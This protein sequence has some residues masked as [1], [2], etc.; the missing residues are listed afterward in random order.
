MSISNTTF[1]PY[2]NPAT[3]LAS[4]ACRLITMKQNK[5]LID[6]V[7]KAFHD[8]P[9]D[10]PY[11]QLLEAALKFWS[12]NIKK[13]KLILKDI[14]KNE[15]IEEIFKANAEYFLFNTNLYSISFKKNREL[16]LEERLKSIISRSEKFKDEE[17]SATHYATSAKLGLAKAFFDGGTSGISINRIRSF[18]LCLEVISASTNPEELFEAKRIISWVYYGGAEDLEDENSAIRTDWEKAFLLFEELRF[19]PYISPSEKAKMEIAMAWIHY[20]RI[21]NIPFERQ[22]AFTIFEKHNTVASA[23]GKACIYLQGAADISID[24][25]K[26]WDL[27]Q[28]IILQGNSPYEM[29]IYKIE[30][31]RLAYRYNLPKL[32]GLVSINLPKYLYNLTV[33]P[34]VFPMD[35]PEALRAEGWIYYYGTKVIKIDH[36]KALH[37]F[38]QLY[39]HPDVLPQYKVE[40]RFGM[41]RIYQKDQNNP[42]SLEYAANLY[43]ENLK[44]K[45]ASEIDLAYSYFQL[46]NLEVGKNPI[47]AILLYYKCFC[48][49]SKL[50]IPN[51]MH[52]SQQGIKYCLYFCNISE[53]ASIRHKGAFYEEIIFHRD[54]CLQSLADTGEMRL[55]SKLTLK[56]FLKILENTDDTDWPDLKNEVHEAIHNFGNSLIL[57]NLFDEE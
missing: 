45:S 14:I 43:R 23:L 3:D 21:D 51:L 57:S 33:D 8:L 10:T 37:N 22:R 9:Y 52:N 17:S 11:A 2:S 42:F 39:N 55:E 46:G 29:L 27:L 31:M 41:A 24:R 19:S 53:H 15:R 6:I 35:K 34:K 7:I 48:I 4:Q 36:D 5:A 13:S 44:D 30:A 18:S 50:Q 25:K 16:K 26:A 20:Y 49:S 40:A 12:G 47:E 38:I 28:E 1:N 32:K 54:L 56:K